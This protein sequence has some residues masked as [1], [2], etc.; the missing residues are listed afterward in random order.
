MPEKHRC[1]PSVATNRPTKQLREYSA[2]PD[3]CCWTGLNLEIWRSAIKRL[4]R[5]NATH[6]FER[7]QEKLP[8][9]G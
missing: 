7:N 8:K 1:Q 3:F 4:D 5:L 6:R 9:I 2:Y